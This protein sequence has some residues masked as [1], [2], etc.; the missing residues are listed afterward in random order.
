ML[1]ILTDLIDLAKENRDKD[2][3]R[4]KEIPEKLLYGEGLK[5][6]R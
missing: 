2:S 3:E 4:S 5:I 6:L 1:A